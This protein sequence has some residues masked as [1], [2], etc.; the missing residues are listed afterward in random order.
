MTAWRRHL[1]IRRR[2]DISILGYAF[3]LTEL[4]RVTR[5]EV[6][7]VY[8]ICIGRM[9]KTQRSALSTRGERESRLS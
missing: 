8:L 9:P 1:H 3:Q 7:S 2:Q 4:C 6:L 5:R